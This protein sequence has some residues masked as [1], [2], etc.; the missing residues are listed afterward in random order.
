[1]L[2][3]V[4]S[5]IYGPEVF[6]GS[7]C[8]SQQDQRSSNWKMICSHNDDG[9]VQIMMI[10]MMLCVVIM[11]IVDAFGVDGGDDADNRVQCDITQRELG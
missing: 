2:L 9:V 11:M 4:F 6:P 7:S 1:M 3:L 8:R 10:M 5:A